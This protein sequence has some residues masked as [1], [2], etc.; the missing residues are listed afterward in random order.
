MAKPRSA[1][2]AKD[3]TT[4]PFIQALKFISLAQRESG[5]PYQTHVVLEH[6]TAT[7]YD[8]TLAAGIYIDEDLTAC[9]HTDLLLAALQKAPGIVQIVQDKNG[10]T[11]KTS[12]D[13]GKDKFK[14]HVPCLD[15]SIVPSVQPDVRV[16]PINNEFIRGLEKIASLATEN[17]THVVT[18]SILCKDFSMIATDRH[19]MLEYWHGISMPT[20]AMPKAAAIALVKCG[21]ELKGFGFSPHSVTFY[22]TDNSWLRTQLYDAQWPD[23]SRILDC[24]TNAWS[25]PPEFYNGV[26]A[27]ASFNDEGFVTFKKNELASQAAEGTGASYAVLG[28]PAGPVFNSKYLLMIE[29][30]AKSVDWQVEPGK[31]AFFGDNLRGVMLGVMPPVREAA[32]PQTPIARPSDTPKE[33]AS[34]RPSC[35][36]GHFA[37]PG[38]SGWQWPDCNHECIPF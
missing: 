9:P 3:K 18:S 34:Q 22:F 16:A 28:L 5:E 8:G 24:K 1:Q 30:L 25:L 2:K 19:I 11:I 20:F 21:K 15:R 12:T 31:A 17:G 6:K 14:A 27:V 37:A 33:S 35:H 13:D 23:V 29:P 38:P 32:Q 4:S 7:A 26:R 36:N 10:L